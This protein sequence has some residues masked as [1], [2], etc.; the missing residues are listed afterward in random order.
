M[1]DLDARFNELVSQIDADERR[2][3]RTAAAKG[4]R[5]PRAPRRRPHPAWLA[6]AAVV[7]ILVAAGAVL[8][9]RPDVLTPD[10]RQAPPSRPVLT[11]AAGLAPTA[12]E[13]TLSGPYD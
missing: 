2:R 4:V 6:A 3:M 1:D 7:A 8:A 5:E 12:V 10:V 11:P 9:F 13:S